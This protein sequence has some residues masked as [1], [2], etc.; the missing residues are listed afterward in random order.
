MDFPSL[1][2]ATGIYSSIPIIYLILAYPQKDAPQ[3][4]LALQENG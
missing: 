1:K 4:I 3:I 2:W